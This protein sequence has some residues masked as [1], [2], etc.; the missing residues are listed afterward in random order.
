M[1]R[2]SLSNS[3]SDLFRDAPTAIKNLEIRGKIVTC[4][5]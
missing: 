1:I 4:K 2:C 3:L 5:C